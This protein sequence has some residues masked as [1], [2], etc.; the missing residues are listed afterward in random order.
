[1]R[2]PE[3]LERFLHGFHFKLAVCIV[4]EWG[5]KEI[6]GAAGAA[7]TRPLLLLLLA[8]KHLGGLLRILVER[9]GVTIV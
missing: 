9:F 6:G 7:I 4:E 8:M 2:F 1:M 3:H 5:D